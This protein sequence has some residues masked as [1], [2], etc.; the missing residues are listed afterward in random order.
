LKDEPTV[1]PENLQLFE[2]TILR[3]D[4]LFSNSNLVARSLKANYGRT[5]EVIPTGVD[6][7]F[8]APLGERS[9]NVRP[10][11]LFVGSLRPFKGPDVV[12]DAAE[13]FPQADF[14]IV[15]DGMMAPMLQARSAK[16]GNVEMKGSLSVPAVREEYR[17]ADVFLFPS[18][19]EG[20]PKVI[21][22][23]AACGLPVLARKN[24][25]P[26]TVV[27]GQTGYLV[28]EDAELFAHLESMFTHRE[29]CRAMGLRGREHVAA[30]DWDIVVRKWE[31]VFI[32][33]A[34][35]SAA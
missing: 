7:K 13:R 4:H 14:V 3:A 16:L 25:E 30:F 21:A 12:L 18:R 19:W 32:R 23:A 27:D 10:R 34:G 26:E 17:R 8:F 22:E 15:G 9:R 29:E 6:T 5:S 24:Y 2:Q 20:S 35:G 28:G 1:T 33:L 31:E 11:V